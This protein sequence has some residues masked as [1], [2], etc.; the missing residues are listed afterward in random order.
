MGPTTDST[1]SGYLRGLQVEKS[2]PRSPAIGRNISAIRC[3]TK[4]TD[5]F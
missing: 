2:S 3:L 1:V 4:N 5:T